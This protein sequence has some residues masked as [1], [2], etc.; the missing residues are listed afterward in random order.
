MQLIRGLHN[1]HPDHRGCVLTI[2]NFDGIHRGHQTVLAQLARVGKE[3]GLPTALI[4]FEPQTR[5]FF[6]PGSAPI[7]LTR[8]R[9]K[10]MALRGLPLDRVCCLRFDHRLAGL[11]PPAFIDRLVHRGLGARYVV[12][13]D[14]FRFGHRRQGDVPMLKAAG[15]RLGFRV[16]QMET[17]LVGGDR[18][19]STRVRDALGSGDFAL[20]EELLG[21]KYS[22][23]GRIIHGDRRGRDLGFPTANINLHRRI[24]PMNGV[25]AVEVHGLGEEIIAGVANVGVRPT[26]GGKRGLL[27]VHL[28][29]FNRDIYT[30]RVQ[31]AFLH[32]F[33]DERRFESLAALKQQIA[34]DVESARMYFHSPGRGSGHHQGRDTPQPV[35]A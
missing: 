33:R 13:G 27:E 15:E 35:R 32:K 24:L 25:F 9:E 11:A 31:V 29:D 22:L 3:M 14:D 30:R 17:C 1:L 8:L 7:R 18:V 6:V 4:I 10:L 23:Y 20:V 21:R 34:R 12:V 5:E 19:S 2:G 28:L 26:I 16:G